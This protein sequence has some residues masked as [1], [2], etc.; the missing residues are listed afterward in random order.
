MYKPPAGIDNLDTVPGSPYREGE[1]VV[2][3]TFDDG[4]SPIY[5]PQVL[6]V[7]VADRA[8]AS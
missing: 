2:A 4:P 8:P 5:T 6:R 7:R 1:K 3:L